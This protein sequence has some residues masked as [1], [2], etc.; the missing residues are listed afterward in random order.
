MKF[1][2]VVNKHNGIIEKVSQLGGEIFVASFDKKSSAN[3]VP[4]DEITN[5]IEG[6]SFLMKVCEELTPDVIFFSSDLILRETA[7]YFSGRKGLG[8]IAHSKKLK[9]DGDRLIGT[10]P[11]GNNLFAEVLSVSCPVLLILKDDKVAEMPPIKPKYVSF[12][13]SDLI[14]CNSVKKTSANPIKTARIVVGVGRGVKPSLMP[15][16]EKFTKSINGEIGCTRPLADIGMFSE[17]R[18]IG[19]T[20]ISI[21]P[22]IYIALGISGAL[23]HLSG[24]NGRHIIAVNSDPNAPIFSKSEISINQP[25]EV[26]LKDFKKCLKSF[27]L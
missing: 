6:C 17:E 9:M 8:L 20:G 21:S 2:I 5:V 22:D 14:Q 4:S 18:M 3:F 7:S 12:A 23:Q 15:E 16:V 24:V 26:V 19:E 13:T 1:L 11:G 10:V 25:V 27:S